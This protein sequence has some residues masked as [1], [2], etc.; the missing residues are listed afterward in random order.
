MADASLVL[1]AVEASAEYLD[2]EDLGSVLATNRSLACH[3]VVLHSW[4]SCTFCSS[5]KG[6]SCCMTC[7]ECKTVMNNMFLKR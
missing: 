2:F 4:I 3:V 7:T 6:V 1:A 5:D